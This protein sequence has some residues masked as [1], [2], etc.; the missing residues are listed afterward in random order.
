MDGDGKG[1]FRATCRATDPVGVGNTLSFAIEFDQTE[2]PE[3]LEGLDGVCDAF[4][5]VRAP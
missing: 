1:H 2:L 4:P 3:I 5:V